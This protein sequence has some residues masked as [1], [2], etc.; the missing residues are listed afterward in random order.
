MR[1][2]ETFLLKEDKTHQNGSLCDP[3]LAIFGFAPLFSSHLL[4]PC[5]FGV[6]GRFSLPCDQNYFDILAASRG[7]ILP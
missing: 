6:L 5:S 1:A 7:I 4:F 2:D 3:V